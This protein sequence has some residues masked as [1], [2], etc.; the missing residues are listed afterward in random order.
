MVEIFTHEWSSIHRIRWLF[1]SREYNSQIGGLDSQILTPKPC[2]PQAKHQTPANSWCNKRLQWRALDTTP[3][4][5]TH[6]LPPPTGSR[7]PRPRQTAALGKPAGRDFQ[8]WEGDSLK[9]KNLKPNK[10]QTIKEKIKPLTSL[11]FYLADTPST[12]N[13]QDLRVPTG[14]VE[15]GRKEPEAN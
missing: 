5:K 9:G 1:F 8:K 12:P 4:L 6:P 7:K 15:Q 3:K 13:S 11:L 10:I 2:K 14:R